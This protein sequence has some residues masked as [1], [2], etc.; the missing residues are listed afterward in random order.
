MDMRLQDAGEI[1]NSDCYEDQNNKLWIDNMDEIS[2]QLD[3]D[4]S[5]PEIMGGSK[6]ATNLQATS[7]NL[8]SERKRRKKLNETLYTLRSVVPKIS[9][10]CF[11]SFSP[12]YLY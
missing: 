2:G 12:N 5:D 9:K 4:D 11:N 8:Q 3:W 7:K 1:F 10:V 6:P